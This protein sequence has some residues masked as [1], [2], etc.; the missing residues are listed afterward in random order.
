[1]RSETNRALMRS[2]LFAFG[3]FLAALLTG[4]LA[5]RLIE[6]QTDTR[7]KV[8][9]ELIALGAERHLAQDDA[10]RLRSQVRHATRVMEEQERLIG[11]LSDTLTKLNAEAA[12]A[13]D[14]QAD[15]GEAGG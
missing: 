4:A 7:R 11:D 2:E 5:V 3:A 12:A 13:A 8:R 15:E 9:A 6:A 10:E 1:M 14:D